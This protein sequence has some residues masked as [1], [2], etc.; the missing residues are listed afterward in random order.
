MDYQK[1]YKKMFQETT[2]AI[3]ILQ[4]AQME[5]EDMYIEMCENDD[6]KISH[7]TLVESKNTDV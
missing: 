5:C 4:Q 1:L 2:K 6:D 3:Y 7:F